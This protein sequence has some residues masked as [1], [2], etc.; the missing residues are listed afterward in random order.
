MY[1]NV[2]TARQQ[3]R[4]S[5]S[6][7]P[8]GPELRKSRADTSRLFGWRGAITNF[9]VRSEGGRIYCDINEL[10]KFVKP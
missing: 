7:D 5:A 8:A 1:A 10:P 3:M 9:L 4:G 6:P 2:V